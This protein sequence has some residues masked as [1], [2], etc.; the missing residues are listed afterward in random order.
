MD[1]RRISKAISG[2]LEEKLKDEGGLFSSMVFP[3]TQAFT[4]DMRLVVSVP[5][6]SLQMTV[7]EP[8]VSQAANCR[9]N[10]LS[11]IIFFIA[12]ARLNVT[13]KGNPSGTATT[14]IVTATAKC[15]NI[16][17]TSSPDQL[18][19]SP[20]WYFWLSN[21]CERTTKV[22]RAKNKPMFPIVFA[23]PLSLT[24]S[25]VSSSPLSVI[26]VIR[27]PHCV[28]IPT[29][30]TSILH[31]PSRTLVPDKRKGLS[32]F[33]TTGSLSPVRLDSLINTEYPEIKRPSAGT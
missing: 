8:I 30:V 1:S 7:A 2:S 15:S 11:F 3:Q 32:S 22:K 20:S 18:K 16:W 24:C 9:T 28:R 33:T 21:P 13:A 5:V 31:D 17:S 4:T 27:L 26:A 6:L 25:G 29:A 14:T 12:N 23:T 19:R 10:A